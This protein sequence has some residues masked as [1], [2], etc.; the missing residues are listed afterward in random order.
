MRRS[1]LG[2]MATVLGSLLL[3]S[4]ASAQFPP[5]T[6]PNKDE[7]KCETGAGKALVKFVGSKAKRTSKCNQHMLKGAIAPNSCTPPNPSDPATQVCIFDSLKGAEA[8][9]AAAIDKVCAN[10]P[11]ATPGCH[12]VTTGAQW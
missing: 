1:H 10:V 6:D 12:A 4:A 11:G 8:K 5:I 9:A 3:A 2:S 7:A